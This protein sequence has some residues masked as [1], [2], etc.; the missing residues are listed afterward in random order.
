LT[1]VAVC[2][3][4]KDAPYMVA[5]LGDPDAKVKEGEDKDKICNLEARC[6][7]PVVRTLLRNVAEKLT[8]FEFVDSRTSVEKETTKGFVEKVKAQALGKEVLESLTPGQQVIKIVHGELSELLG[9]S[10]AKVHLSPN[11][12][13]ILMMVGLHGSGKTTLLNIIGGLDQPTKGK[14][15]FEDNELTE[16]TDAQLSRLRLFK[17]GFVFQSYNLIPV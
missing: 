16:M 14:L 2:I 8:A 9:G 17:I 6:V 7:L 10:Y 15:Y 13:T 12:P 11:P 1:S 3:D 5:L 4:A